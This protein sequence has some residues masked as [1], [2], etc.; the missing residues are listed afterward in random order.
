MADNSQDIFGKIDAILGKR[1]GFATGQPVA[2]DEFPMLTEI[3]QAVDSVKRPSVR[4]EDAM[5][6]AQVDVEAGGGQRAV[7][8]SPVEADKALPGMDELELDRLAA[9]LEA[10]LSELFIRQQMRI[11][12]LVRQVVREELRRHDSHPAGDR[13]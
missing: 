9:A 3:V 2:S 6:V 4:A 12:A 13:I 1:V 11:E 7:V 10:R 8:S 5:T